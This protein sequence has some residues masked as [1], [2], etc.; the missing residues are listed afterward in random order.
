MW[1]NAYSHNAYMELMSK[2]EA[3]GLDLVSIYDLESIASSFIWLLRGIKTVMEGIALT[4]SHSFSTP[5]SQIAS[6]Q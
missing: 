3:R 5:F 4:F 1:P 6:Q 2:M